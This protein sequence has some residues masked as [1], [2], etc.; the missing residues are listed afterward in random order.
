MMKMIAPAT[1]SAAPSRRYDVR[2]RVD[3]RLYK[4]TFEQR[5]WADDFA[6]QF[7][8][9]D[10][11]APTTDDGE[12][13][14]RVTF[15]DLV[16]DYAA[17][18]WRGWAPASRRNA[19]RELARACLF[20]VHPDAPDLTAADYTAAD[21]W[22][23]D[24]AMPPAIDHTNTAD[25]DEG[26]G[27]HAWFTTWSLPL[28]VIDDDHLHALLEDF[29]SR[30]A[31][32]TPRQLA[33]SSMARVRAVLRGAFTNAVARRLIDWDLWSAVEP[34][35]G[36]EPHIVDPDLVMTPDQI[37]AL[38]AACAAIDPRY[39]A[40][41]L[42][43]GFCGLRPSEA[44][45]L[46]RRRLDLD[47]TPPKGHAR[48]QLQPRPRPLPATR[49]NPTPTPQ[50]SR[51]ACQPHHPDPQQGRRHAPRPPR[52]V[53]RHRLRRA[54]VH[55]HDR[56]PDQPVQLPPRHL[57]ARRRRHLPHRT[58]PPGAPPGPAARRDH[59]VANS[60]VPLKVA[61]TWSG[62]KA[63]SVLLDTYLG[64]MHHDEHV[65]YQRVEQALD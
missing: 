11:T 55:Q 33:P 61:Q 62:H 47:A 57:E 19:V 37:T 8:D 14:A 60:G 27:W 5:G 63:L 43:Q 13:E 64:V 53:H 40:F 20:L 45:E 52:A 16:V 29:R 21:T 4:Y 22:L 7:I 54:R 1:A 36:H 49:R 50:G 30:A 28:D 51:K 35:A 48:R 42:I 25:G 23:R 58:A 6:R 9:P 24:T 10:A 38:A 59:P 3:G 12:E 46:R 17:R 18:K 34:E 39:E 44:L 56:R 26:R 41:V 31:D 32:G 2:W 65:A 15:Y